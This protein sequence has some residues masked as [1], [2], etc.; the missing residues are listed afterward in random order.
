RADRASRGPRAEDAPERPG[1]PRRPGEQERPPAPQERAH[2]AL[3]V[4]VRLRVADEDGAPA[5][6]RGVDGAEEVAAD[7]REVEDRRPSP[8]RRSERGGHARVPDRM[9]R[10]ARERRLVD[11]DAAD[12]LTAA[13]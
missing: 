2:A 5:R 3:E 4:R 1:E 12:H 9:M 8:A 10:V 13:L 11:G 7:G 6:A